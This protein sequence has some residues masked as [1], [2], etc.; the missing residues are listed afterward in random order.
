MSV[1][2]RSQRVFGSELVRL[3]G[4]DRRLVGAQLL[5]EMNGSAA[6]QREANRDY[7]WLNIG[8]TDSG[9]R[10]TGNSVWRDPVTAARATARWL[11]GEWE[12]PGFGRAAPGIVAWSRTAGRPLDVQIQALQRSGW[13]SSGYPD[14]P[15]LVRDYSGQFG[16]RPGA[17]EAPG[18]RGGGAA[19][20]S[21]RVAGRPQLTVIPGGGDGGLAAMLSAMSQQQAARPSVVSAPLTPPAF[22]AQARV[23]MPRGYQGIQ[24][25]GAPVRSTQGSALTEAL[26]AVANAP[27]SQVQVTQGLQTV[28]MPGGGRTGGGVAAPSSEPVEA[29]LTFMRK[30]IGTAETAGPNRGALIDAWQRSLGLAPGNPW[31][32]IAV[33]KALQRA[34]VRGVDSRVAGTANIVAMARAGEGGFS[35]L[36]SAK[37]VRPGDVWVTQ[38]GPSGHTGIVERVRRDGQIDVLEGNSSDVLQRVVRAREG[39]FARPAYPA[40]RR[41]AA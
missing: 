14:L 23:P 9:Q 2:T 6:A 35:R 3:T 32:G 36:V 30:R 7:N 5:N 19:P 8:W 27:R 1:L 16:L 33:G 25:S 40:R 38:P 41:A 4:L 34:G 10:G 21:A 31:C 18:G 17:V 24:T 39:Y 20:R 12:V 11:R 15:K 37:D 29:A 26:A 13:A 22:S 28:R